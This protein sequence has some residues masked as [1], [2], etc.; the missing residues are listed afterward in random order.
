MLTP[1]AIP[2]ILTKANWDKEKGVFAKMAG[3]TGIGEAMQA[4]A[5][6]YGQVNWPTFDAKQQLQRVLMMSVI[7]DARKAATTEY[8]KVEKLRVKVKELSDLAETT[9]GIFKKKPLIPS[10][11]TKHVAKVATEADTFWIV[12][13]GNSEFFTASNKTFDDEVEDLHRKQQIAATVMKGYLVSIPRDAKAVLENPTVKEYIGEGGKGFHQGIR[14]LGAALALQ[15]EPGLQKYREEWVNFTADGF[16]PKE[17]NEVKG[18]V[19]QVLVKL[20][21]LPGLMPK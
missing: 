17:D 13:K 12:L 20:K 7:D 9:A 15:S 18:K 2:Q 10:S 21:E 1:P 6:A 3:K 4:V 8:S 5:T 16:K 14:G 11:S 19:A